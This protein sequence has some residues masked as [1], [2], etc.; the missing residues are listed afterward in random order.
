MRTIERQGDR[1]TDGCEFCGMVGRS[2]AMR[3]VFDKSARVAAADA[4]VLLE[5]ETGTG[6]ELVARAIHACGGRCQGPFEAVSCG[7]LPAEVAENELFGHEPGAFTSAQGRSLG[8]FERANKGTVFLDEIHLLPVSVQG[9]LLRVLQE[10]EVR[11]LGGAEEIELDMRIIAASSLNLNERLDSGDFRAELYYR[12]G[13]VRIGLPPLRDRREDIPLLVEHFVVGWARDAGR[14]P[15]ALGPGV[16]EALGTYEWPGNV[17]ELKNAIEGAL[18]LGTGDRVR[19][20][21]LPEEV[22]RHFF[23]V[24]QDAGYYACQA[25]HLM[26][27]DRGY[28]RRLLRA[29]DGNVSLVADAAGLSRSTV[30]RLLARCG[31]DP[32]DFRPA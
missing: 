21:E 5:G 12:L 8:L 14:V 32:A 23:A 4:D 15:P 11:R 25:R 24:E 3:S 16:L 13:S 1:G 30:Y 31:V 26:D 29:H 19:L 10:R 9:K 22:R 6:K 28:F 2:P 7:R 20:E 27:S 18:I 17:R